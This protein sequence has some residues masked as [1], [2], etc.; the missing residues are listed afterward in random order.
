MVHSSYVVRHLAHIV[1]RHAW[2]SFVFKEKQVS[3]GRLCS[4]DLRR[5]NGFFS[6]AEVQKEGS[7]RQEGGKAIQSA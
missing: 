6:D 1:H 5:K 4:F 2:H 7:I 3:K